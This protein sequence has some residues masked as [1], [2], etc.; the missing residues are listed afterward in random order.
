MDP[1]SVQTVARPSHVPSEAV[2]PVGQARAGGSKHPGSTPIGEQQ[3]GRQR[4]DGGRHS[5][6]D[7][8]ITARNGHRH[9]PRPTVRRPNETHTNVN[10]SPK[11]EA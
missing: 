1:A 6:D 7:P 9:D 10:S 2:R 3:S 11:P 5:A 4:Q 8:D